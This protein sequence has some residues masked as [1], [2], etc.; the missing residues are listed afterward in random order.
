MHCPFCQNEDTRVVDSR[1]LPESVRRRRECGGCGQRFTT[2]E[3]AEPSLYVIKKD[4]RREEFDSRK[5][6]E[7]LRKACVK[8]P[9]STEHLEKIVKDIQSELLK[10]GKVEVSSEI[11]GKLA[12]NQLRALDEVAYVRFASVYREFKDIDSLLEEI[13]GYREWKRKS[14]ALKHQLTLMNLE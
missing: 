6:F 4:R 7:G 2:Y 3:R 9:I 11:I 14:E 10:L 5:L 13:E 8:R 12:M 1:E